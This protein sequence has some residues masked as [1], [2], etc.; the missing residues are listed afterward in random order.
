MA[1]EKKYMER[2]IE[3]A[4]LGIGAVNTNTIVGEV[5]V[6]NDKNIVEGYH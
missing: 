5:I 3:L 6:K 4:R 1:Y 2:A